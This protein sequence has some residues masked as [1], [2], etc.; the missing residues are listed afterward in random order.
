MAVRVLGV[1]DRESARAIPSLLKSCR[2]VRSSIR[3]FV[4]CQP[5]D[6]SN[7]PLTKAVLHR[8]I[9]HPS[10]IPSVAHSLSDLANTRRPISAR[11]QLASCQ[12]RGTKDR[13]RGVQ[14][15]GAEGRQGSVVE[16]KSQAKNGVPATPRMHH[17]FR[18]A[19]V[20]RREVSQVLA[21]CH[22]RRIYRP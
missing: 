16:P 12:A 2:A 19:R 17:Q 21:P 15:S 10:H 6:E 13:G 20:F 14:G 9:H 3:P 18:V 7:K 8:P 1:R 22:V 5:D 11:A 4:V